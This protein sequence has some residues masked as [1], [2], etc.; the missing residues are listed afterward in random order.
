[1]LA[2]LTP[3]RTVGIWELGKHAAGGWRQWY[4]RNVRSERIGLIDYADA[5][6]AG[7]PDDLADWTANDVANARAIVWKF[8]D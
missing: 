6:D 5:A 4:V 3:F 7:L 8:T 1:M 2:T